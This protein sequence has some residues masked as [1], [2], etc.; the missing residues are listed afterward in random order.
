MH[1]H[2]N[3][4]NEQ[5]VISANRNGVALEMKFPNIRQEVK[6]SNMTLETLEC[7]KINN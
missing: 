3:A 5:T 6:T 4:L 2:R 1:R 7:I